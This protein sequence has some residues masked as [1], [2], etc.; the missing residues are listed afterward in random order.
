M[1]VDLNY[2]LLKYLIQWVIIYSLFKYVP[3]DPMNDKDIMLIT[4]IVVLISAVIENVYNLYYGNNQSMCQNVT[5]E[6]QPTQSQCA[7]Y[8][9]A[10]KEHLENVSMDNNN[11]SLTQNDQFNKLVEQVTNNIIKSVNDKKQT[12]DTSNNKQIQKNENS[13][14]VSVDAQSADTSN[15]HSI[16][17]MSDMQYSYID[18]N[19]M[20]PPIDNI[21]PS[22]T[23]YSMIPPEKWYPIPPHPPVCVTDKQCPVC[24]VYTEGT[25]INLKDWDNS[26]RVMPPDNIN[27]KFIE[28]KLNSGDSP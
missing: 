10:K 6:Q 15:T 17:S 21:W 18:Y 1:I 2:K 27:V 13:N 24:P 12:S 8:C 20:P 23:S 28:E 19:S 26:R 7:S 4:T 5:S 22:D 14:V 16:D 3:N 25:N 9:S 11:F